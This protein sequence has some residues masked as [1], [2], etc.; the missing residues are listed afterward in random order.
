MKAVRPIVVYCSIL[1]QTD[2]LFR[3]SI[4]G[5]GPGP[6]STEQKIFFGTKA[7]QPTDQ[8][9][10][11]VYMQWCKG[12]TSIRIFMA[13]VKTCCSKMLNLERPFGGFHNRFRADQSVSLDD[14][15]CDRCCF[16]L[17]F[18]YLTTQL[19]S[20]LLFY[21]LSPAAALFT[22]PLSALGYMG[23]NHLCVTNIE[24]PFRVSHGTFFTT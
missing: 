13:Y 24:F 23:P 5:E 20:Y 12:Q 2:G 22:L 9:T 11:P 10:S 19:S 18:L 21:G 3:T 6:G 16:L 17:A 8:P 14:L 7:N 1:L 4:L 15:V